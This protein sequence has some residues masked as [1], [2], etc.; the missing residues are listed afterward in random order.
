M[1]LSDH[2]Q[3]PENSGRTIP[4]EGDQT[5]PEPIVSMIA[6]A[7]AGWTLYPGN[8]LMPRSS[9]LANLATQRELLI[10]YGYR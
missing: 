9:G 8:Q 6:G 4:I 3:L 2:S 1:P 5:D 10:F 7:G